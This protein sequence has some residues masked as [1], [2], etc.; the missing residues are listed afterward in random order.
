DGGANWAPS[1]GLPPI[2]VQVIDPAADPTTPSVVW[3]A[4]FSGGVYRSTDA[5]LTWSSTAFP[6]GQTPSTIA[7]GPGGGAAAGTAGHAVFR[8]CDGGATWTNGVAGFN[9]VTVAG[10]WRDSLATD[11]TVPQA[12]H[13]ASETGVF[14][15]TDGGT[16]WLPDTN[17]PTGSATVVAAAPSNPL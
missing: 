16:T 1:T 2:P 8:S 12:F 6:G 14:R 13:V 4:L 9:G 3:A 15:T 11:P 10:F 5:G 7:A 17:H